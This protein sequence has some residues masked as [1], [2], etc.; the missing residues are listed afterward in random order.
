MA[1][2]LGDPISLYGVR[3]DEV[4][5]LAERRRLLGSAAARSGPVGA[6]EQSSVETSLVGLALSGGGIRSATTNLGM[7]QALARMRL[8]P[9]MDYLCT[10]S[11]G[12]YIG[13]C[14]S[15][16]LSINDDPNRRPGGPTQYERNAGLGSLFTTAWN[17]FPFRDVPGGW[18][19]PPLSPDAEVSGRQQ[20]KHLRTHGNFLV[21]RKGLLTAET[22][23]SIG[24]LITGIVYHWLLYLFAAAAL[25]ALCLFATANVLVPAL[26]A[27]LVSAQ[28]AAVAAS[29][30]QPA[31]AAAAV[32]AERPPSEKPDAAKRP[33][34]WQELGRR[35]APISGALGAAAGDWR[36]GWRSPWGAASALAGLA[37]VGMLFVVVLAASRRPTSVSVTPGESAEDAFNRIMLKWIRRLALLSIVVIVVIARGFASKVDAPLAWLFLPLAA[38]VGFWAV[39]FAIYVLLPWAEFA[40]IAMFRRTSVLL[41]SRTFRSAW[42]SVQALAT[43]WVL[44]AIALAVFPVAVY[45]IRD[46][47]P[48]TVLVALGTALLSR[49]LAT[50]LTKPPGVP[51]WIAPGVRRAV[52]GALVT[53]F[54]ALTVLLVG[55]WLTTWPAAAPPPDFLAIAV[56]AFALLAIV[57]FLGNANKLALHYFYR[58]RLMETYLRTEATRPDDPRLDVVHDAMEMRLKE[59]HG[60]AADGAG[61]YRACVSTAPYHVISA[62]INLAERRDLTRKDRKSGYFV[63]SKLYCGSYHTGFCR[64]EDYHGGDVKL[65]RALTISGAAVG[66]GMGYQTFFAQ[67]F[68]TML[69]NLRLGYWIENPGK[70]L[71]MWRRL[72]E[73]PLFSPWYLWREMVSWTHARGRLVNLSDGGHTGDNVGIYPLLQRRCKVI[74]ACDA[75]ADPQMAFGSFTEALRHAYIDMNIDVDI[76][77]TMLRPDPATGRSRSHCAVG[78]IRYPTGPDQ[79][80]AP[81][82]AWLI[83]LKNSLIG[84]EPEP[85]KNYKIAHADFPHETTVDQFFDDAQFESYRA[86]GDHLAEHTF[87]AFC[88]R[89]DAFEDAWLSDLTAHHGSFKAA[90]DPD[91]QRSHERLT[92]LEQALAREETLGWYFEQCY[93]NPEQPR[94]LDAPPSLAL[95][96]IVLQQARLMENVFVV[97]ELG[98]HANAPDNRG[99]IQLFRMW[100]RSPKFRDQFDRV[101]GTL[102]RDFVAFYEAYLVPR[103]GRALDALIPHPWDAALPPGAPRL[104]LDPG[105]REAAA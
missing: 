49:G 80:P 89:A 26:P 77:L 100:A 20:V 2:A 101:R 42:G 58:D 57:G 54:I 30:A 71:R 12:G 62:A 98:R 23:R 48:W 51:M 45:A 15:A 11:G 88:T 74:I 24:G 7:L 16:L 40:G 28:R 60:V 22:L 1:N 59:L 8:L 32:P 81:E 37:A 104:Y 86:L 21:A 52:L 66:P 4:E 87:G 84:D 3:K 83:Y 82:R 94:P 99:W 91:Y 95:P 76:D 72:A 43:Y 41:W 61:K 70:P 44:G 63:F 46:V 6:E 13:G 18:P 50:R 29:Q 75:E 31:G 9:R 38:T 97:L 93:G 47:G 39:G 19:V 5:Y 102:N 27:D 17:R 85:M 25:A 53:V 56:L 96:R 79:P 68:A 65:S 36:N 105:R 64:T 103:P 55:A 10:V 34:A 92:A 73:R 69:F 67:A 90:A 35:F 33:S 78:R 14:L